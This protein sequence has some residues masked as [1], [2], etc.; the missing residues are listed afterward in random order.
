MA[1]NT[2]AHIVATIE[3]LHSHLH[4]FHAH[5]APEFGEL[6]DNGDKRTIT[7]HK[8]ND[9]VDTFNAAKAQVHKLLKKMENIAVDI[10]MLNHALRVKLFQ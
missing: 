8:R 3:A 6:K 2:L 10:S 5:L 4:P 9:L 7:E 1:H